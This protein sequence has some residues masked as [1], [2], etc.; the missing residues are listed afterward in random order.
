M[1]GKKGASCKTREVSSST[2]QRPLCLRGGISAVCLFCLLVQL[3][4]YERV[5]VSKARCRLGALEI[6]VFGGH[7]SSPV[8]LRQDQHWGP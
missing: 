5:L 4:G 3:T 2:G 8:H 6:V 1:G 7:T